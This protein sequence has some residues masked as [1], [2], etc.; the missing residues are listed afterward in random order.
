MNRIIKSIKNKD[1]SI[2]KII[3]KSYDN[4][5]II[6]GNNYKLIRFSGNKKSFKDTLLG[7]DIGFHSSG[8]ISVSIISSI[9]ALALFIS[10]CPSFRI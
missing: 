1:G 3:A 10:M 5:E 7:S 4:N 8:F 2:D 9:I 6:I